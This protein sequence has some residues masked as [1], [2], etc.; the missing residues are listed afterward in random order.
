MIYRTLKQL[1]NIKSNKIYLVYQRK[2]YLNFL[3]YIKNIFDLI[4]ENGQ[5]E[6]IK[7]IDLKKREI[8]KELVLFLE[9]DLYEKSKNKK[10]ILY[11]FSEESK[12]SFFLNFYRYL[13]VNKKNLKKKKLINLI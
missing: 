1:V 4:I 9:F 5:F 12:A 3:V 7:N 6:I 8:E 11:L 10:K 2:H 13:K